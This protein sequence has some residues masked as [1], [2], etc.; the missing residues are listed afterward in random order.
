MKTSA[1]TQ[2]RTI[3]AVDDDELIL[4]F[5]SEVL[6]SAGYRVLTA[7]SGEHALHTLLDAEPDLALLDITMPNMTGLELAKNLRDE[8]AVP[9]MFLTS[10]SDMEVIKT[11]SQFGAL[12]YL[13]KPV[14]PMQLVSGVESSLARAVEIKRLRN[15]EQSLTTALEAGRETSMAVGI[16]M[17]RFQIDRTQAFEKLRSQARSTRQKIVHIAN[18]VLLSVE[19][20]IQP[21]KDN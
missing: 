12:G 17:E 6:M 16:L 5:I 10:S 4:K 13:L 21:P 9:F 8:T 19:A 3:L 11:A 20:Q 14:Q 18:A 15:S 1:L 2:T 7:N